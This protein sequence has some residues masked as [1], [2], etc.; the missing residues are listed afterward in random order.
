[1]PRRRDHQRCL[2]HAARLE[3]T[4]V[5]LGRNGDD[6]RVPQNRAPTKAYFGYTVYYALGEGLLPRGSSSR[7][8]I[9]TLLLVVYFQ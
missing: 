9:R 3:S 5:I 7:Y 1:M 4:T 6:T 2:C 8:E